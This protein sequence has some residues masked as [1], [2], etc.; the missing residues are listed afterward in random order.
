MRTSPK[1]AAPQSSRVVSVSTRGGPFE[2]VSAA[3][4]RRRAE[5]MLE[6]LGLEGVELSVGLVNDAAIH[7]LNRSFRHKDKPTD[8]LSFSL[9]EGE[10]APLQKGAPLPLGDIVISI[11]TAA[12][13]AE[14]RS[15]SLSTEISTLVVHG[16]LH[17][18]GYD[19]H[20]PT[21]RRKMF[22]LQDEVVGALP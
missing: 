3:A 9:L 14:E 20:T 12:R 7:E 21:Q 2:G 10:L 8:V 19:H 16:T 4:V 18:M 13:Q 15:H 22:G 17:L 5:K 11:E 6:H 1:S